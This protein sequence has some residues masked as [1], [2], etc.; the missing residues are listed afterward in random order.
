MPFGKM[1]GAGLPTNAHVHKTPN[2][3]KHTVHAAV[4]RYAPATKVDQLSEAPGFEAR[5]GD[6]AP[7][8]CESPYAVALVANAWRHVARYR[9]GSSGARLAPF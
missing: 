5:H 2:T 7:V 4:K 3:P 8:M 6:E 9:G 1:K